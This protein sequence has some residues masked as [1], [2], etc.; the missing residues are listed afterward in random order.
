MT[1]SSS[2][3]AMDEYLAF[4]PTPAQIDIFHFFRMTVWKIGLD[5]HTP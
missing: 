3:L 5:Y 1:E 4:S 2:D